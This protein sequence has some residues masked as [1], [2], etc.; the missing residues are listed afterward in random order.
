[1]TFNVPVTKMPSTN[2]FRRIVCQNNSTKI[3]SEK[4]ITEC[5]AVYFRLCID[6]MHIIMMALITRGVPDDAFI[7]VFVNVRYQRQISLKYLT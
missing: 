5:I 7:D 4:N 1:M 3:H 6:L 2:A